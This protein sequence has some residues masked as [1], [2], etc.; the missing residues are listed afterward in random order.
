MEG[1]GYR[2]ISSDGCTVDIFDNPTEGDGR[3]VLRRIDGVDG[4]RVGLC[5]SGKEMKIASCQG[6]GSVNNRAYSRVV[7]ITKLRAKLKNDVGEGQT[8]WNWQGAVVGDTSCCKDLRC[9]PGWNSEHVVDNRGI[10]GS[11]GT[12]GRVGGKD[13][14]A[15]VGLIFG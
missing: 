4:I 8:D 5:N 11:N 14:L 9:L 12:C 15:H 3:I 1:E 13:P 6:C 7:G 2:E 10:R